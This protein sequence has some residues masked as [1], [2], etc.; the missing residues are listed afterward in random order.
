M[1]LLNLAQVFGRLHP[2]LV[3]LPIGFLLLGVLFELFSY[4]KK[5]EYLKLAVSFTLLLGFLSAALSCI[6]GYLLSLGGDY[7]VDVLSN[8][9]ISGISLAIVSGLLYGLSSGFINKRFAVKRSIFTTFCVF[10]MALMAY[11]GH[12]GGSLT[13][14]SDYLS[15][16]LLTPE[17]RA[18]PIHIEEA[19][20]FEDIVHPILIQRCSQCH[21]NGKMKGELSM[22]SIAALYQGG[23]NGPAIVAGSL[24]DSELYKRITLDPEHEKYMP[25]DGKTPLTKT[26]VEIIKWWIEKAMGVSGRK[27]SEFEN[28]EAI[29]PQ[30]ASYLKIES[31]TNTEQFADPASSNLNSNIPNFSNL[32]LLDTLRNMG[33]NIRI[34]QH[35]PLMLDV[36]LPEGNGDKISLIK[37]KIKLI[38][39][40]VIWLNLSGNG[41]IDKEL[42][43]LHLLSNLEKLRLENNP[44][45]DLLIPELTPLKYLQAIN[46]NG[47]KIS[48]EGVARLKKMPSVK[49]V[50]EWNLKI[51]LKNK[52]NT[53]KHSS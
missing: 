9:K 6:F 38:A 14:G 22:K 21:N 1:T 19:M 17:K 32:Q 11:T 31:G 34:M 41:L 16:E 36:T 20:I 23:K 30:I 7:Q 52:E 3:H 5:F 13:H 48:K 47:T 39:K 28:K 4:V 8:H 18:K 33:V 29:A 25:T 45:T 24:K 50:Y 15:L 26:E 37:P 49:R 44:L 53:T 27:M 46:L 43:F 51:A 35:K 10:T 12:Q 42:D 40:Q 2:L